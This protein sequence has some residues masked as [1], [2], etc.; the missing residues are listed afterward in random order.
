VAWHTGDVAHRWW[1]TGGVAHRR[2]GTQVMWHICGVAQGDVAH[3]WH[4]TQVIWHTGIQ[5]QLCLTDYK[6][7]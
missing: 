5:C 6:H 4:G 1:H 2:H 7:N 3:R